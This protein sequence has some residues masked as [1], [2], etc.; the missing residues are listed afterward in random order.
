M[1][2]DGRDFVQKINCEI[3]RSYRGGNHPIFHPY[4]PTWQQLLSYF[5]SCSLC[6]IIIVAQDPERLARFKRE[7]KLLASL[8]HTNIAT[9]HG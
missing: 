2:N 7:A 8:N 5:A 3:L 9:I 6:T 4:I 1:P